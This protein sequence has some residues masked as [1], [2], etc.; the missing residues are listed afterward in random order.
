[1]ILKSSVEKLMR[2]EHLDGIVC[3]QVLDEML[4][5]SI[6]PLQIAAFLFVTCQAGNSRRIGSNR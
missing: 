2:R 3:Q 4:D 6:N 5:P 1:M